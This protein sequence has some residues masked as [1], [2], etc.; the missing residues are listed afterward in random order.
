MWEYQAA[1]PLPTLPSRL[2][3]HPLFYY[4]SPLAHTMIV[5]YNLPLNVYPQTIDEPTAPLTKKMNGS[6]SISHLSISSSNRA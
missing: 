5:Q 4:V 1:K 2:N 6:S 3:R